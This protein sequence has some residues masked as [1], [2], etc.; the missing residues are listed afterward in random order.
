M[1]SLYGGEKSWENLRNVVGWGMLKG[2]PDYLL[3]A[4]GSAP[5]LV[6]GR[7]AGAGTRGG[8]GWTM[9]P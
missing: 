4:A 8:S 2:R 3:E 6:V 5:I 7:A 1:R 9:S